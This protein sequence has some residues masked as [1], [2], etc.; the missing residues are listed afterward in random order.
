MSKWL[1]RGMGLS[2]LSRVVQVGGECSLGSCT[3][4][5]LRR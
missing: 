1:G 5:D 2:G 4:R 3:V